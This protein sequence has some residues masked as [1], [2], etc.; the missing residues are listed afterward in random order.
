MRERIREAAGK[1]KRE[2]QDIADE[3]YEDFDEPAMVVIGPLVDVLL[4]S[5]FVISAYHLLQLGGLYYLPGGIMAVFTAMAVFWA[6]SSITGQL[7]YGW[8]LYHGKTI[9]DP[10]EVTP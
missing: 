4:V 10:A 2:F 6:V 7:R 3:S 5:A 8:D 9:P 1:V